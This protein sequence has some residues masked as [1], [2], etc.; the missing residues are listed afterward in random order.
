LFVLCIFAA[1]FFGI[2]VHP[3]HV[4]YGGVL[5]LG[6]ELEVNFLNGFLVAS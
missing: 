1:G 3:S 4:F 2:S 5:D 6:A